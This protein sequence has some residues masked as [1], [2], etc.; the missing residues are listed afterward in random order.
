VMTVDPSQGFNGHAEVVGKL[1][2]ISTVLHAP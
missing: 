1:T 2:M